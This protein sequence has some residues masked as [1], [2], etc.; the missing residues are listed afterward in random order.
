MGMIARQQ[1]E[2]EQRRA[3]ILRAAEKVFATKGAALVTMDDIAHEADLGKGTLYLYFESKDELYLEIA[4][5]TVGEL[6]EALE[7]SQH[8]ARSGHQR[9]ARI[10]GAAVAF[11]LAHRDPFRVA[12]NWM[13]SD[14]GASLGSERFAEYR[15]LVSRVYG[16]L[17]DALDAGK[18][19]GSIVT[20]ADTPTLVAEL[21]GALL[22]AL[23]VELNAPKLSERV[24]LTAHWDGLANGVVRLVLAGLRVSP[25]ADES[26]PSEDSG[27][28]PGLTSESVRAAE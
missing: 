7:Q 9:V 4:N 14:A 11:A 16:E 13:G 5:R 12:V 22:G 2:K 27:G 19:D 25:A 18:G 15:R 17:S 20:T 10:L 21:L 23:L 24:P 1:W 8:D 28:A 26:E 6:V 3:S